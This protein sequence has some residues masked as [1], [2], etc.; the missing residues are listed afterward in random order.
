MFIFQICLFGSA[1]PPHSHHSLS[2]LYFTAN[3]SRMWPISQKCLF[4]LIHFLAPLQPASHLTVQQKWNSKI[5]YCPHLHLLLSAFLMLTLSSKDRCKTKLWSRIRP[6][7]RQFPKDTSP[8]SLQDSL[9]A[10]WNTHLS[11][12]VKGLCV[13][14]QLTLK[15]RNYSELSESNQL[16]IWGLKELRPTRVERCLGEMFRREKKKSDWEC[17]KDSTHYC[18]LSKGQWARECRQLLEADNYSWLTDRRKLRPQSYTCKELNS[19]NKLNEPRTRFSSGASSVTL[20]TLGFQPCGALCRES[21]ELYYT[22][23]SV[24]PTKAMRS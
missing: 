11:T 21:A 23:I 20:L 8:Y 2:H 19:A 1:F 13:T 3:F 7:K 9:V 10:Q 12:G 4:P 16:I 24:I 18:W 17:E 22:Q 6:C 15:E 5:R 14:Y